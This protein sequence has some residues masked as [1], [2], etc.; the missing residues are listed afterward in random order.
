MASRRHRHPQP[1]RHRAA[2]GLLTSCDYCRLDDCPQGI[3]GSDAILSPLRLSSKS[4]GNFFLRK[5]LPEGVQPSRT[6]PPPFL[7]PLAIHLS[8][9]SHSSGAD[10]SRHEPQTPWYNFIRKLQTPRLGLAQRMCSWQR[11]K[12]ANSTFV[13]TNRFNLN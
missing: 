6:P 13:N 4:M 3:V 11:Q 12:T 5:G 2:L 7:F 10:P 1:R 8:S 9:P